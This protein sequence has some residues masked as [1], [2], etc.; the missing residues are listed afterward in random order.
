MRGRDTYRREREEANRP[1]RPAGHS[2]PSCGDHSVE[3]DSHHRCHTSSDYNAAGGHGRDAA[4]STSLDA[5]ASFRG[6]RGAVMSSVQLPFVGQI[7]MGQSTMDATPDMR[8]VWVLSLDFYAACLS[9]LLHS[10]HAVQSTLPLLPQPL[11]GNMEPGLRPVLVECVA[12]GDLAIVPSQYP[13]NCAN[14][15]LSVAEAAGICQVGRVAVGR[16]YKSKSHLSHHT[17]LSAH[18]T[19]D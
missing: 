16:L 18:R 9:Q 7:G 4:A 14:A 17:R 12:G 11:L 5:L 15:E 6:A 13:G 10:G 19:R 8:K 2:A 3:R 1:R